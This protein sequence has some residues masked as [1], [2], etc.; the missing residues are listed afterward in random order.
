MF[1]EKALSRRESL[2]K[3]HHLA[4]RTCNAY[5]FARSLYKKSAL[6]IV[7]SEAS[8]PVLGCNNSV[9]NILLI[10]DATVPFGTAH[11]SESLKTWGFVDTS[12]DD[13]TKI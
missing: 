1:I 11:L 5:G 9:S 4:I 13:I 12:V 2:S 10:S 8:C 3:G 7:P 6:L